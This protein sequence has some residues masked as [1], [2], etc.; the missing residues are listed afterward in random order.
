M[1][2]IEKAKWLAEFWAQI[3]EGK[4]AQ[5]FF[6]RKWQDIDKNDLVG[7]DAASNLEKWRIKPEPRRMWLKINYGTPIYDPATAAE[8]RKQGLTVTEWLEVI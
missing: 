1:T 3:A 2:P 8:W 5:E 6:Q 7:P 4:T